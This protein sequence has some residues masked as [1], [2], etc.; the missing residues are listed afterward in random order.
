MPADRPHSDLSKLMDS[1]AI[2]PTLSA[3]EALAV[4]LQELRGLRGTLT[5]Q[6]ERMSEMTAEIDRLRIRIKDPLREWLSKQEAADELGVSKR[7]IEN[8]SADGRLKF[9]YVGG[10]SGRSWRTTRADLEAFKRE[11]R[12]VH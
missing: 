12:S 10:Q 11:S 5:E 3:T 8:Y 4:V 1:S 6:S 2:D 9:F 7:S